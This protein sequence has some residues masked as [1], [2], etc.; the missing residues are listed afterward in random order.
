M[1]QPVCENMPNRLLSANEL[2]RLLPIALNSSVSWC[3]ELP[4]N[5]GGGEDAGLVR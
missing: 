5:G 2:E 4:H 1:Q 3:P